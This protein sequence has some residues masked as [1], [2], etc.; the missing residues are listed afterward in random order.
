MV[1]YMAKR[2]QCP[3]RLSA[4]SPR[5]AGGTASLDAPTGKA[6]RDG[7][8]GTGGSR[9]GPPLRGLLAVITCTADVALSNS[10]TDASSTIEAAVPAVLSTPRARQQQQQQQHPHAMRSPD[11]DWADVTK[12]TKPRQ[13]MHRPAKMA[14]PIRQLAIVSHTPSSG[15]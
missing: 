3:C 5:A 10:A 9:E 15:R 1:V 12:M 4:A 14:V 7:E 8:V 2:Q 6:L 13:K 11:S